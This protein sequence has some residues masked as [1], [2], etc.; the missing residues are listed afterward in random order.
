MREIRE[1]STFR[2]PK[3]LK[4]AIPAGKK[5]FTIKRKLEDRRL[6]TICQSGKCPNIGE[7]WNHNHATMMIMGNICSRNCLFCSVTKGKPL[8]LDPRE[9]DKIL[10]MSGIMNLEY[11]VITSVTRD[12]LEDGGSTHFASTIRILRQHHPDLLIEVLIPDFQGKNDHLENVFNAQPDVLNHNLETIQR[13]YPSINRN[14]EN[15]SRSLNVL[16]LAHERGL[17]TKSG[18]MVGLGETMSELSV[19]FRDLKQSGVSLLTIG[20]YLQPSRQ[21]VKVARYYSPAEFGQLKKKVMS[22]GFACVE[23]GPLVRSSYHAEKHVPPG[24]SHM[25]HLTD[26]E[27]SV[28]QTGDASTGE[29]VERL[30]SESMAEG[31]YQRDRKDTECPAMVIYDDLGWSDYKE[32]WDYQER[33]F[34]AKVTE[35]GERNGS[36]GR[37]PDRLIFVEHN[38]VYTL[39]KSGSD[40]NLLLDYIQLRARDASF[41]RIDRG[42]DIGVRC[43]VSP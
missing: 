30:H 7:C 6:F 21:Q 13:I 36:P 32:T 22:L 2:K 31:S 23:A 40:Q 24:A 19:L 17:V 35:K 26:S 18:I 28:K 33:F 5:Y 37:T 15:Y 34:N 42:G 8:P 3:W 27:V 14:P 16:R 38:H 9:P 1:Q 20:Q 43:A 4:V 29:R 25:N 12:D 10:E 11:V 41:Y 39:G